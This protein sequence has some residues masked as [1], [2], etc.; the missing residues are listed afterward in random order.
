MYVHVNVHDGML[1]LGN[2]NI[3]MESLSRKLEMLDFDGQYF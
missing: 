3:S 1:L 2:Q